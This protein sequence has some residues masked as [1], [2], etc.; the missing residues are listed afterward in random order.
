MLLK[1][2]PIA[3]T[4]GWVEELNNMEDAILAEVV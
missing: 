3:F 1:E 4:E 2:E